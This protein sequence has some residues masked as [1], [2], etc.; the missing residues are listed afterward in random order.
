MTVNSRSLKDQIGVF[1]VQNCLKID[2]RN[3]GLTFYYTPPHF[4]TETTVSGTLENGI[5]I[6][7]HPD[8]V[9]IHQGGYDNRCSKLL[10][11]LR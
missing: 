11:H 2:T 8:F 6:F 9:Y 7:L 3:T 1:F 5:I 4:S 10:C